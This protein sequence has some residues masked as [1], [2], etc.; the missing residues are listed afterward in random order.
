MAAS[1]RPHGASADAAWLELVDAVFL[2]DGYRCRFERSGRRCANDALYVTHL[3]RDPG[4]AR[5][6]D[7]LVSTCGGH[8]GVEFRERHRP[9][10][11]GFGARSDERRRARHKARRFDKRDAQR[12]PPG[13]SRAADDSW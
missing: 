6:P 2:R 10:A 7:N 12:M 1:V 9:P 4:R 11:A 13:R 3:E 8:Y 5:D